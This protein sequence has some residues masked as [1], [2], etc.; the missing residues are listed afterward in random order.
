MP[1]SGLSDFSPLDVRIVCLGVPASSC[2]SRLG[3]GGSSGW[4]RSASICAS[5][6]SSLTIR[7]LRLGGWVM[8]GLVPEACVAT[9]ADSP[10]SSLEAIGEIE[11]VPAAHG[12]LGVD[13]GAEDHLFGADPEQEKLFAAPVHHHQLTQLHVGPLAPEDQKR[14]SLG[15][16]TG[17]IPVGLK[18]PTQTHSCPS[19]ARGR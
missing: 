12:G 14:M 11:G 3:A 15:T 18:L 10:A 6:T 19:Q 5:A 17:S 4:A 13:Q 9:R 1:G 7:L 8:A 2:A 16:A